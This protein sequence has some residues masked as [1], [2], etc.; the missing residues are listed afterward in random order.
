MIRKMQEEDLDEVANI[1]LDT[2]LKAH[3]FIAAQYWK[4]NWAA[5]KEQLAQAELSRRGSK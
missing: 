5:V 3:S 1:W 4:D 2:N